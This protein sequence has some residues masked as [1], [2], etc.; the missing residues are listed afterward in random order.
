MR[1]RVP[2]LESRG[3]AAAAIWLMAPRAW[4][5]AARPSG[6]LAAGYLTQLLGGLVLVVLLIFVLAWVLRRLPAVQGPGSG[7]IQILAVRSIGARERLMLVQVGEEQVL[8]GVSPAG[9]RALHRLSH[10]VTVAP[11][12]QRPADFAS[13]LGRVG[14]TGSRAR[15]DKS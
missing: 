11:V 3:L 4:A 7:L 10:P 9:L 1:P 2:G 5:D 13:L 12:E 6:E 8:V 15:V 14:L